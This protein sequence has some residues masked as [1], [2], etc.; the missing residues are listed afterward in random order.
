MAP[1]PEFVVLMAFLMSVVAFSVDAV[2]PALP[3]MQ[4]AFGVR[5]SADMQLV[6]LVLFVSLSCGQ[7]IFGPLSDAW[8]RKPTAYVGFAIFTV[9]SLVALFSANLTVLL[10]GRVLQ[11]LG[12]AA[13][14]VVSMSMVRD[15]YEGRALARVNSLVTTTFIVVPMVAPLMGYW[16]TLSFGWQGVFGAY[17]VLA[18]VA[19]YWLYRRQPE[20][21]PRAKRARLHWRS[22]LASY[23]YCLRHPGA[24]PFALALGLSFAPLFGYLGNAHIIFGDIYGQPDWFPYLFGSLASVVGLSSW[25]NSRHVM[26]HGPGYMAVRALSVLVGLALVFA[27]LRQGQWLADT[28]WMAYCWMAASFFCYGFLFGNLTALAL[29]PLGQQAGVGAAMLS[30]LSNWIATALGAW[31]GYSLLG[32]IDA[33]VLGQGLCSLAALAIIGFA[34]SRAKGHGKVDG[35]KRTG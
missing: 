6:V 17:V 20:T 35:G 5:Q 31:I 23:G 32:S 8:G 27:L 21:L 2:L 16:L 24:L 29:Q 28:L 33:L 15:C 19:T 9:G 22:V 25:L 7:L 14:R 34:R 26:H 10:L 30:T 11:G 13:P 4:L 18:L 12:A 1:M 3:S